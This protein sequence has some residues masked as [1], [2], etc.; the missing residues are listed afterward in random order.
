MIRQDHD[1]IRPVQEGAAPLIVRE[2]IPRAVDSDEPY[3]YGRGN[4]AVRVTLQART[5]HAG[6]QEYRSP[7][8]VAVIDI[9]QV[10]AISQPQTVA[11]DGSWNVTIIA[12]GD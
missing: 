6:K 10:A 7:R 12:H 3:P 2:P 1:I 4:R 5:R 8:W 11:A 9:T